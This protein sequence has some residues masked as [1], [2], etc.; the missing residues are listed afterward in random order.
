MFT[1]L[2]HQPQIR[3]NWMI[4]LYLG[5]M[6]LPV[7]GNRMGRSIRRRI[8]RITW[9]KLWLLQERLVG[10]NPSASRICEC[11]F[12]R[13]LR[14]LPLRRRRYLQAWKFFSNLQAS[15]SQAEIEELLSIG[16]EFPNL[17][18][19]NLESE[20][21]VPSMDGLATRL[22]ERRS[23]RVDSPCRHSILHPII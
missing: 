19:V 21:W 16:L 10:S 9:W 13:L 2:I 4:R 8:R 22:E 17:G 5:P 11:C 6:P 1:S 14:G 20:S 23:F 18:L 3:I 7:E 12:R 15:H